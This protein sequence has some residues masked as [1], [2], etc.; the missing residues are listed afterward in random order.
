MPILFSEYRSSAIDSLFIL[1]H[2]G[3][4][5]LET[6]YP[7]LQFISVDV[8][9]LLVD[10][11]NHGKSFNDDDSSLESMAADIKD[12]F[13]F[14]NLAVKNVVVIGHSLGAALAIHLAVNKLIPN[15][16]G[17]VDVDVVE[18]SA[19]AALKYMK[20]VI[21]KRPEQFSSIEEAIKWAT[22]TKYLSESVAE[23]SLSNQLIRNGESYIWRTNLLKTEIFWQDWFNDLS[24]KFLNC[25]CGKLL[26][27]ASTNRLDT[28]LTIAQMQGKFQLE[29][30]PYGHALHEESPEAFA[31]ILVQFYQRQ[32]PIKLPPK[33]YK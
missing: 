18:G 2:G 12:T 29:I 14:Y 28:T 22:E 8:Q 23:L 17:I 3:G 25:R 10:L 32:L 33:F 30:L 21:R 20:D 11:R 31:A 13:E 16:I 4:Y 24:S 5:T 19:I 9:Y 1:I 27:L 6:W 15:I 26:I 7:M